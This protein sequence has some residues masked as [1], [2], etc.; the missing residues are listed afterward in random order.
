MPVAEEEINEAYIEIDA[1]L[2][3][4]GKDYKIKLTVLGDDK[5]YKDSDE[6]EYN[7]SHK[8]DKLKNPVL[9]GYSWEKDSNNESYKI[10]WDAV[11]G[12]D[13]YKRR[14]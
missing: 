14:F 3:T 4:F 6:T 9:K 2:L 11:D 7:Y 10:T 1:T 8:K 5:L 13:G 12:A